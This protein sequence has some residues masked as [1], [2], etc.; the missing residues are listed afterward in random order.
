MTGYSWSVTGGTIISGNNTYRIEVQWTWTPPVGNGSTGASSVSVNYTNG[1]GCTA[2]SPTEYFVTVNAL[3][4]PTI[5]GP[6]VVCNNS[7]GNVYTTETGNNINNYI[8]AVTGGSITAGGTT[9]DNTVTVT[10]TTTGSV[11]VNYTDA[12][13][14]TAASPTVYDVTLLTHSGTDWYVSTSGNDANIGTSD[15]PFATIQ[16][17]I[18]SANTSDVV[19]VAAGTYTELVTV[20]KGVT[21][22][23][24]DSVSTIIRNVTPTNENI[25]TIASSNVTLNDFAVKGFVTAAGIG[26]TG[27]YFNSAVNNISISNVES[28]HHNKALFADR[29]ANVTHLTLSNTNL[30]YSAYGFFLYDPLI[31]GTVA[32]MSNL[33]ITNGSISN[34]FMWG[35]GSYVVP[36]STGNDDNLTDVTITGTTFNNNALKGLYFET[37]N[38]AVFTNI[39][40][41]NSGS[42]P[43][44]NG[45]SYLIE[46]AGIDINLKGGTYSNIH[47]L[48]STIS[49]CGLGD[50]N[51]GGILVKARSTGGYSSTPATLTSVVIDNNFISNNG[52]GTYSAGIR[53]GES[54]GSMTGLDPGPTNVAINNNSITGNSIHAIRNATISTGNV[55]ATCNWYGS[56]DY[57]LVWPEVTGSVTFVPYLVTSDIVTPV[58]TGQVWPVHNT[59]RNLYYNNIQDAINAATADNELDVSA[60]TY[61]EVGQI[62]ISQNL[63][64][65]GADKT[66]TIIKPNQNTTNSDDGKAWW[67]VSQNVI[68]NLSNV[69]LDGTG[70]MIFD[71]IRHKGTGTIHNVHFT[72]ITYNASGPDYAGF[73]IYAFCQDGA[74][75][76]SNCEFDNIGREGIAYWGA[77]TT[78]TYTSNTYTGKGL[79]NWLDYGVEVTNSAVATITGSTIT[80]CR[81]TATLDGS[82][83]AGIIVLLNSQA[84]ITG[85]TLIGNFYGI[86]VGYTTGTETP[87]AHA[88][89]N[90]ISGN[91]SLGAQHA[92]A[93]GVFDATNNYWG[94]ASGPYN[95][96]SNP[97]G[98]GNAVSDN[99]TFSPWWTTT[100]GGSGTAQPITAAPVVTSPLF[101][102]ATSVSGTST[103]ADGTSI[104]IFVGASS[105]GTTTVT[106]QAWTKTGLTAMTKGQ[107]VTAYATASGKCISLV[108][109]S[110]TV[111]GIGDAYQGGKIFYIL[112]SYDPGYNAGVQHGFIAANADLSN[113]IIWATSAFQGLSAGATGT[114]YGTGT[115]NTGLIVTQ[116][117]VGSDYAAGL[118]KAYGDGYWYLPSFQ[119]LARL[120]ANK[121]A[122]GFI[123]AG[124]YWTSSEVSATQV[125]QILQNSNSNAPGKSTTNYVRAIRSF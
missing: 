84:T 40:I 52:N 4:A 93:Y 28:S 105:V 1:N 22:Q 94:N 118:A 74:V 18:N 56:A 106:T 59:T 41:S 46:N 70:K 15:C 75:N 10:W 123:P 8:W 48:N 111:L 26:T 45:T 21:L 42:T 25:I 63:S 3:P 69:T 54:F 91:Y 11:S 5:S 67:L 120:F 101:A 31:P 37:L 30:T 116:N 82:A 77:G 16:H 103:E 9:A 51:G 97:C 117:G 65:V 24:A 19:H 121:D 32:K 23:G 96:A 61:T 53:I 7:T 57:N 49:S 99:V 107:V 119:E 68:F 36:G 2:A 33:S 104:E 20:N 71:G 88:N 124:N 102:G 90:I 85:S 113:G 112:Q 38:N 17:G 95:L 62:V 81:G 58:C 66:T 86:N 87:I 114:D 115:T 76:V 27:I 108:S 73:A 55:N 80:N 98:T 110:V 83:S 44:T 50:P 29:N 79:G 12:N 125:W 109:N 122:V 34:N 13:T 60:G 6:A 35:F 64:I 43:N 89:N 78:G 72:G 14:C 100:S 92:S 39:T 47:V